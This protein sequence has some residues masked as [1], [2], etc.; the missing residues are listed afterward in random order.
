MRSALI[1]CSLSVVDATGLAALAAATNT[2]ASSNSANKGS[3]Y[4]KRSTSNRSHLKRMCQSSLI[5]NGRTRRIDQDRCLLH[6]RELWRANEAATA[7]T[8]F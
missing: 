3:A 1:F 5:N 7:I 6:Q 8:Q 4:I 2:C